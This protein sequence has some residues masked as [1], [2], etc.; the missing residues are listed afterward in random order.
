[1]KDNQERIR[2]VE[3]EHNGTQ[4]RFIYD[5]LHYK[6]KYEIYETI[7]EIPIS[8]TKYANNKDVIEYVCK[9]AICIYAQGIEKGK[10]IKE[11]EIKQ[12]LGIR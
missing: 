7:C 2:K 9:M 5:E 6:N 8:Y 1:M 12:V 3:F 4:Y 10:R 11:S